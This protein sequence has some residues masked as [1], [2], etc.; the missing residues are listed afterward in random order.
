MKTRDATLRLKR[1]DATEKARKALDLEMMIRD[2]E[3]MAVDLDRQIAVEEERT[4]VKDATHFAYSTFAKAAMQRRENLRT[5][6]ADLRAKL[7]LA[8]QDQEL[9]ESELK[10][11]DTADMMRDSERMRHKS[12]RNGAAFG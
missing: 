10:A 5:S 8:R 6:V 1:F 7:D 2:F 9:A 4:G 11:L 12:E 3:S